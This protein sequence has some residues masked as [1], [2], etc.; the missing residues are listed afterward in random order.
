MQPEEVG[1]WQST[2]PC[3]P[4]TALAAAF[5]AAACV[6]CRETKRVCPFMFHEGSRRPEQVGNSLFARCCRRF[7]AAVT[8]PCLGHQRGWLSPPPA[9]AP[10]HPV[11]AGVA[12]RPISNGCSTG[13]RSLL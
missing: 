5:E 2:R 10:L 7:L 1:R 13:P 9:G 4:G 8:L 12:G 3:L 6:P 11:G